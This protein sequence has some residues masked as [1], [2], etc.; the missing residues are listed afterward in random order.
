MKKLIERTLFWFKD[1][2]ETLPLT[3][4]F[5]GLGNLYNRLLNE[6]YVGKKIKFINIYFMT[7]ETYRLHPSMQIDSL[8]FYGGY[9][10][11]DGIFDL[12]GF[13]NFN[14]DE[15]SVYIWRRSFEILRESAILTKNSSLSIANEHAYRKGIEIALNPDYRVIDKEVYLNNNLFRASVWLNFKKDGMYSKF[16]LEKEGNVMFEKNISKT[17]NGNEFFLEIYKD[18]E[19]RKNE[20][21]IKGP[22]DVEHLPMFISIPPAA[23][24]V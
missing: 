16:T 10:R 11:Y 2:D 18:I 1:G 22:K 7:E 14:E 17:S 9:L 20:V 3:Q 5:F 4:I 15:Q 21:I 24:R 13:C 8:H 12:P 6:Q 23:V 19:I